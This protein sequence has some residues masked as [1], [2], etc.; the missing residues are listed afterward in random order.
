MK[1]VS[2][3]AGIISPIFIKVETNF[4]NLLPYVFDV[5]HVAK[6]TDMSY[7][8]SRDEKNEQNYRSERETLTKVITLQSHNL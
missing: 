1:L 2:D 3:D 7:H 5:D 4:M 6:K 8:R